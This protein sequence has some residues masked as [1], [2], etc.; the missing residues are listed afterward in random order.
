[1]SKKWRNS[2]VELLKK[3]Y[4]DTHSYP[5]GYSPDRF[6]VSAHEFAWNGFRRLYTFAGVGDEDLDRLVDDRLIAY[7]KENGHIS[8]IEG[9][10]YIAKYAMERCNETD[11]DRHGPTDFRYTKEEVTRMLD[12]LF[13]IGP[14]C[15]VDTLF[16]IGTAFING[17]TYDEY[18]SRSGVDVRDVSYG[19]LLPGTCYWAITVGLLDGV[20]VK[21]YSLRQE[22]EDDYS[23]LETYLSYNGYFEYVASGHYAATYRKEMAP[24]QQTKSGIM[25]NCKKEICMADNWTHLTGKRFHYTSAQ[26]LRIYRCLLLGIDPKPILNP[27]LSYCF[28]DFYIKCALH[29]LSAFDILYQYDHARAVYRPGEWSKINLSEDGLYKYRLLFDYFRVYILEV[30]LS[31]K[32][33]GKTLSNEY[34]YNL[35]EF[36][37]YRDNYTGRELYEMDYR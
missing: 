31:A 1:M 4:G 33:I 2:N 11:Y 28:M 20:D 36:A 7:G 18:V 14:Y 8:F 29:N 30:M 24:M 15:D 10:A 6:Y 37:V 21:L 13:L 27:D 35:N 16:A 5:N 22:C 32:L 25:K 3:L 19:A 34:L 9:L 12:D 23:D 26:M 17:I